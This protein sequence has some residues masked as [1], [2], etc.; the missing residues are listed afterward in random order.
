MRAPW[1][2]EHVV[3]VSIGIAD[4][5]DIAESR[6]E[7]LLAAADSALYAAKSSGRNR[8]STP[9]QPSVKGSRSR[10]PSMEHA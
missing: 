8:S 5:G 10:A 3:T 1:D 7:A 4:L 9:P 2:P 6:P